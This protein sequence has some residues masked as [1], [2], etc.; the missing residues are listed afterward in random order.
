M[1]ENINK[2]KKHPFTGVVIASLLFHLVFMIFHEIGIF[3]PDSYG[4]TD[5][6]R[7]MVDLNLKD[8]IGERTPGYPLFIILTCGKY[9]LLA[10]LQILMDIAVAYFTYDIIK[11][12]NKKAALIFAYFCGTLLN[13]IFNSYHI[14]T[15]TATLFFTTLSIWMC[16]KYDIIKNKGSYKVT[17]ITSLCLMMTFLIRPMFIY[18][19][20]I[21]ATFMLFNVSKHLIKPQLLKIL[22][23]LSF[24]F[25]SYFG[26]STLNYYN[27]QWFTVT[28]FYGVNLAQNS[29]TFIDK[30]PDEHKEIK[31]TYQKH[32]NLIP[33]MLNGDYHYYLSNPTTANSYNRL[34]KEQNFDAL[35]A[36]TIWRAFGEIMEK[37]DMTKVELSHHLVGV[38]KQ[39]IIDNPTP[40]SKQVLE[41]WI[42]FWS[43]SKPPVRNENCRN[44]IPKKLINILWTIQK[45]FIIT[46]TILLIPILIYSL[47]QGIKNKSL[48]SFNIFCFAVLIAG[49][50]AQALVTYGEN[51]RF[52]FPMIPLILIIAGYGYSKINNHWKQ[53]PPKAYRQ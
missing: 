44:N 47:F 20:P 38:C 13:L 11:R 23:I 34:I 15:E 1:L 21:L 8:Y 22:I 51:D 9:E 33:S 28:T 36:L 17:V 48:F 45:V 16:Y 2:I 10:C 35:E 29:V 41:N 27:H 52:S 6:G 49:S 25:I 37:K 53:N 24:P 50:L 30:L 3:S 19:T 46:L 31:E 42:S 18:I 32:I 7:K 4:Y 39:L 26:W 14:H 12:H 40:Y 43:H 5:L